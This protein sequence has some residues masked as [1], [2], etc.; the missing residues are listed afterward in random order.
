[1]PK[2]SGVEL[3]K[4]ILAVRPDIPIILCTGYSSLIS[5]ETAKAIGI[6]SFVSKPINRVALANMLRDALRK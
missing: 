3:A 5:K 2:M 1:M 4:K 6:K